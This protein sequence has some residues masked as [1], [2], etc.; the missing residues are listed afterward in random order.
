MPDRART[1]QLTKAIEDHA[2]LARS[3]TVNSL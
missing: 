2:D 1:N 3:V